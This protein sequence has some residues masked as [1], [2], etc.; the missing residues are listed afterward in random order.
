[1]KEKLSLLTELIKMAKCDEQHKEEEYQFLLT[2]ANHLG[3]AKNDF[4]NLFEEYIEFTPPKSEF[5][6]ILQ[7][8]RLVLLMNIDQEIHKD[9]L[10][11]I[12]NVGI[13]MGLNALATN[14]VLNEMHHYPNKVIPADIL[15]KIFKKHHN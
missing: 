5:E 2:I 12:K 4:D 6:R 1:M 11:Y 14:E 3:V 10:K 15:I 13:K 8:Q 9:E 7:F